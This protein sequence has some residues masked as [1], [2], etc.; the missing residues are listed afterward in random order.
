MQTKIDLCSQ[1]LLK[2]GE[3]AITSFTD[4]NAASQIANKLYD[5][6]IDNLLC[7]HTWRFATK[8]YE[9]T[10]TADGHFPIP[11][12]ILRILNSSAPNYELAGDK[13]MAASDKIEITGIARIGAE[14]FPAYFIQP[15]VT[16][17]A[18][19]FSIPLAGNRNTFAILNALFESE[20]RA[21]KFIDSASNPNQSIENFSLL[22]TRF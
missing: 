20:L 19:G 1:A 15:A 4:N 5:M 14:S 17:L 8:K 12:D 21:A 13:I 6:T 2:I 16:K 10:K 3:P 7:L 11:G 18:M 9:L 22:T